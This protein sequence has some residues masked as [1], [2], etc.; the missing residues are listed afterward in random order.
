LSVIENVQ[1]YKLENNGANFIYNN[2]KYADDI[3]L[4]VSTFCIPLPDI[5]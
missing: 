4:E 1:L 5:L 3:P 2:K